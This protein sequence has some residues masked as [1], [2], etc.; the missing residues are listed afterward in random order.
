M[1]L[2]NRYSASAA[3]IVRG[4]LQDHDRAWILGETT[5]GK[6]LV[7]TV[8]PLSDNTG[9][10]LTTAHY[11]TPS[12]RLIQRDYSQ[13]LVP[14]LLLPHQSRPEEHAGR[15]DDRQRPHGLRRRRH[16]AGREIRRRPSTTSSRSKCS[17]ST[18]SS[19]SRRS[20][21]ARAR[22][23]AAQGLGAGRRRRQRVPR[24]S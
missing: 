10:A 14:G 16:H 17:G 24:T 23:E 15:E 21:S 3:E 6:G 20:T 5:F 8:F 2:V 18:R 4:A 19:I 7:Q 11:Y 9:L 1:V 22:R 12:G 13:H